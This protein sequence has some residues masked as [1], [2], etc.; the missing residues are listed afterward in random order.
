MVSALVAI[1]P[2]SEKGKN[3]ERFCSILRLFQ[4]KGI[5][6]QTSIAS[7]I[8]AS[9]S[10]DVRFV[11]S[12]D[13]A[14]PMPKKSLRWIIKLA[15]AVSAHVDIV[16]VE[17]R[18]RPL[19]DSLQKRQPKNMADKVL[20]AISQE[21]RAAGVSSKVEILEESKTIAHTITERPF[22]NLSLE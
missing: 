7:T 13:A 16:Y 6:S 3:F 21:F 1:D 8:H 14:V 5:L 10:K 12:V 18:L 19:I 22:L 17:P 4:Q 20:K 15:K 11:L 9:L 2:T